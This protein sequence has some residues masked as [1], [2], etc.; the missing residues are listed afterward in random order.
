M[1]HILVTTMLDGKDL[2]LGN[3]QSM[4]ACLDCKKTD[5]DGAFLFGT[6]DSRGEGV[7][8][9]PEA[10]VAGHPAPVTNLP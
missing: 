2:V 3:A 7:I 4:I 5:I 6:T 1:L 10:N 8:G 9:P